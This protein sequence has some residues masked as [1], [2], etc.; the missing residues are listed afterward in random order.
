MDLYFATTATGAPYA[1]AGKVKAIAITGKKRSP[2]MP[3]VATFDESGL[4]NFYNHK[5][6][7]FGIVGPAG[8]PQPVVDKLSK[9]VSRH[10]AQP[11]FRDSLINIGLDPYPSTP[12]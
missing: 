11:E 3:D 12:A 10:L 5:R 8:L 6:A 1:K 9:E 2:L 7:P 4:A